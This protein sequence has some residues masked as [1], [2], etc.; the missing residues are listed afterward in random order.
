[1]PDNLET[2]V[3]RMIDAG[4]S[5]EN[6]KTVIEHF[7]Q[8]PTKPTTLEGEPTTF[9]GGVKK[10][11]TSGEALDAG[12]KGGLGW[13]KGATLDLPQSII[14]GITGTA[15]AI[16]HPID[17]VSSIPDMAK[18][19][20][21]T[22][23]RAGSEP[24]NFG[25][26]MG[27]IGGQPLVTAGIGKGLPYVKAPVGA[28]IEAT[29]RIMRKHQPLSGMIPRMVEP[30]IARTIERNIG[31]KIENI[32]Q[33]MRIKTVDGEVIPPEKMFDEGEII[34][35]EQLPPSDVIYPPER[36]PEVREYRMLPGRE[37]PQLPPSETSFYAGSRPPLGKDRMLQA[38]KF[39]PTNV[40]PPP[41]GGGGGGAAGIIPGEVDDMIDSLGITKDWKFSQAPEGPIV[42]NASGESAASMEAIKRAQGMKK[43]GEQFVVYDKTGSKKILG[44]SVDAHDYVAQ[45]YLKNGES[46]G[47]ERKDGSFQLLDDRGGKVPPP[48]PPKP[49]TP[50]PGSKTDDFLMRDLRGAKPRFNVGQDSFTPVFNNDLDKALYI[51]AQRKPS[52]RDADFLKFVQKQT[53]LDEAGARAAG[54]EVRK[55]IWEQIKKGVPGGEE[56]HL[57]QLF[58][59]RR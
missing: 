32:G 35:Q 56:L 18:G 59:L 39:T 15:N 47:L 14:G 19:F 12:L 4:E 29:G 13:L 40:P 34:P 28:G 17:T 37:Q 53:G 5:E 25:R 7:H 49:T 31:S 3:Q 58:T 6:I 43:R 33:R 57:P 10:S 38:P 52:R 48:T 9:W 23:M 30:R 54:M 51:I 11:L 41:P 36:T 55:K 16:M 46:F 45:G 24:E 44:N 26:M 2:I 21:D 1:M 42:N 8:T 50:H 22:V 27:Q 20:A